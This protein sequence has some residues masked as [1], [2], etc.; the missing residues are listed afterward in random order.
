MSRGINELKDLLQRVRQTRKITNALYLLSSARL[1]SDRTAWEYR[2]EYAK[3]LQNAMGQILYS[4]DAGKIQSHFLRP[5]NGG[6]P[7]Y[8]IITGDKGLCGSYN[9]DIVRFAFGEIK[10]KT[11]LTG[12]EPLVYG[13]GK[14]CISKAEQAGIRLDR[15]LPGAASH[16][17]VQTS[18]AVCSELLKAYS[19][20]EA[21]EI[22]FICTPYSSSRR[23]P[24]CRRL[25]PLCADDFRQEG[26]SEEKT[27]FEPDVSSVFGA[28]TKAYLENEVYSLLVGA[29]LSE[30]HA[31][32]TAMKEA[33]DKADER[34]EELEQ[35]MNSER[36]LA[37]TNELSEISAA[38]GAQRKSK[39]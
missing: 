31:R 5:D 36:Q 14:A 30:N 24:V 18:A 22:V 21:S 13:F 38:A 35:T 12:I 39:E 23:K 17:D 4:A 6:K 32:M 7:L 3:R 16:P 33:T 15:T 26:A 9:N 20:G 27:V 29:A 25:L 10:K 8:L 28:V 37:I 34:A 11:E 1:N 19:D 2:E